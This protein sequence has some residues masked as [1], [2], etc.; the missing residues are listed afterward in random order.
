VTTDQPLAY[1]FQSASLFAP[2]P[3][4]GRLRERQPVTPVVTPD[5]KTAWLVSRFAD[6]RLVLTDPRFSRAAAAGPRVPLFGL[7]RLAAGSMLGL[8]PPEHT[9]LRRLVAAAFTAR[10]VEQLRPRVTALVDEL[11]SAMGTLPR[12]VD[13]VEH[14]SVPLPLLVI[15][16]LLGVP[17]QDRHELHAW[18]DTV[19]RDWSGDHH[20]LDR[21]LVNLTG[22]FTN[23][24][25]AKRDQPGD[26]LLSA[27]IAARDEQ[28]RLSES[29]LINTSLGLL[30]AGHETTTAH[31]NMSVL[32]L[33]GRPDALARLRSEPDLVPRAVDELLRLNQISPGGGTLPRVTV[34]PVA[35]HGIEL[36]TGS[37]VITATNAANRDPDAFPDP[38]VL[39]LDRTPNQY[40]TFG[41][42]IHHCLGSALARLQLQEALHGLLRHMPQLRLTVPAERLTFKQGMS[43]RI[44]ESLPIHW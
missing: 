30:I 1:P 19:M 26:D 18:S 14:F 37:V 42:G 4:F 6:V 11:L 8:D 28:D 40:L 13:L 12:P 20:E 17:V 7:G 27:L 34:E 35:L 44:L 9:R 29:E 33:A 5:G 16:E 22:Y 25:A 15:C 38:D 31:L 39:Q 43:I 32:T 23:L 10:R 36:G 3:V 24:A 2:S 21:V 41:T